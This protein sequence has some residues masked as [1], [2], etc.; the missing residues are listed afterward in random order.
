LILRVDPTSYPQSAQIKGTLPA[1]ARVRTQST[2]E[3]A[4]MKKSA[5]GNSDSGN[6]IEP[7]AELE[8]SVDGRTKQN[9]GEDGKSS[10]IQSQ[11]AVSAD[12]EDNKENS[13]TKEGS[14]QV[15]SHPQPQPELEAGV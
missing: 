3:S 14:G 13:P 11:S 7:E 4:A 2:C 9:Q 6:V 1:I 5:T 12:A 15:Q 10:S 8:K